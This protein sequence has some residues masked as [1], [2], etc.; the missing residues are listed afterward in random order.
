MKSK[1]LILL[2][3]LTILSVTIFQNIHVFGQTVSESRFASLLEVPKTGESNSMLVIGIS[4]LAVA[5]IA[6]ITI[7]AINLRKRKR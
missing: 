5:V 4:L 6:T 7:I 1:M 2:T 3:T